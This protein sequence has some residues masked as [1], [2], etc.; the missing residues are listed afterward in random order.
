MARDNSPP[1]PRGGTYYAGRT[2]NTSDLE[3]VELEGIER[4]FEDKS[5][6]STGAPYRTNRMV[7]C[8]IMRNM[9]TV[10]LLPKRVGVVTLSSPNRVVGYCNTTAQKLACVVDEFLPAAGVPYG[11]LFWG[12]VRG[13]AVVKSETTPTNAIAVDDIL[14]AATGAAASTGAT[15]AA[16]TGDAGRVTKQ[17]LAAPTDAGSTTTYTNQVQNRLGYALSASTTSQT[18]NDVLAIVD[19]RW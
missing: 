17:A 6:N 14:V 12:V 13:P 7:L 19:L 3:G 8:R 18:N 16:T 1:F 4:E 10:A 9:T 15:A 11:D 2:I 5:W